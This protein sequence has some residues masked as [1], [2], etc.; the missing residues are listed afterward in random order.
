M[1]SMVGVMSGDGNYLMYL[2][3]GCM[4]GVRRAIIHDIIVMHL[5]FVY[6][7]IFIGVF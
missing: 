3:D 6:C 5:Y 7:N 4:K 2:M 1:F